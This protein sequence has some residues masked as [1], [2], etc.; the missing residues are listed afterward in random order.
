M[1]HE[2]SS[3]SYADRMMSRIWI[4]IKF[5]EAGGPRPIFPFFVVP[6]RR[7]WQLPGTFFRMNLNI[8][9]SQSY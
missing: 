2:I 8:V 5:K 7:E 3:T 4:I 6:Y 1:L 9:P